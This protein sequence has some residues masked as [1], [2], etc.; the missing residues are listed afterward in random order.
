[1]ITIIYEKNTGGIMAVALPNQDSQGIADQY[2]NVAM[3]TMPNTQELYH[4]NGYKIDL[5][6]LTLV[7][8]LRLPE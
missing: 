2:D 3:I 7:K 6:T 1:M 8:R 5:E 4:F